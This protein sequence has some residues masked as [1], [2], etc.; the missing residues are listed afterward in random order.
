MDR[1][2]LFLVE[3]LHYLLQICQFLLGWSGGLDHAGDKLEVKQCSYEAVAVFWVI[4]E[5]LGKRYFFP[6]F[7]DEAVDDQDCYFEMRKIQRETIVADIVE[8][9]GGGLLYIFC[10]EEDVEAED[11]EQVSLNRQ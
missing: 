11:E 10:E 1:Q 8:N 7:S 3:K 4:F 6:A 2:Q 9:K 5:G